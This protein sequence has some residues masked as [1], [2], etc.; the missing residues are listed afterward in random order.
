MNTEEFQSD[1][2]AGRESESLSELTHDGKVDLEKM[3][4]RLERL[5]YQSSNIPKAAR[6]FDKAESW[7]K[8]VM[9]PVCGTNM[10]MLKGRKTAYGDNIT[11]QCQ[12]Q[13]APGKYCL[14]VMSLTVG[15]NYFMRPGDFE[16]CDMGWERIA[17]QTFQLNDDDELLQSSVQEEFERPKATPTNPWDRNVQSKVIWE[18]F[19]K[20]IM[21]KGMITDRELMEAVQDARPGDRKGKPLFKLRREIETL[22]R[23]MSKRTGYVVKQRGPVLTVV[24]KAP[25]DY[26]SFPFSEE[27]YRKQ[28]GMEHI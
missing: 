23:W 27:S 14:V 20:A 24:G 4:T 21:E 28:H 22:P 17:S 12:A 18:E 1:V 5:G 15:N 11:Y 16:T 7:A 10:V 26:N 25:G 8:T 6:Y 3:P 13:T 19:W 2:P 9:C